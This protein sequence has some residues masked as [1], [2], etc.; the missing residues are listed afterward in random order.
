MLSVL[1]R[2]FLESGL[3]YVR[4]ARARA[5]PPLSLTPSLKSGGL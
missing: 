3:L 1:L 2:R 5:T 4:D